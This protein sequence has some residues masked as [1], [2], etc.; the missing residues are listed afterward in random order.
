MGGFINNKKVQMNQLE[1]GYSPSN[2]NW[3]V[4]DACMSQQKGF[5][6]LFGPFNES[7]LLICHAFFPKI[8]VSYATE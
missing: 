7:S 8:L 5:H 1:L 3:V 2:V 6:F 4:F